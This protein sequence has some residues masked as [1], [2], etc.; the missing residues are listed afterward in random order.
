MIMKNLTKKNPY[1]GNM[2]LT[3]S[4]ANFICERIKERLKPIVYEV[5]NI[6]THTVTVDGEAYDSNKR[7]ENIEEKLKE[8][9][10]L[11]SVSAYLRTAI[12]EKDKRID[13][14]VA[15]SRTAYNEA[16][17]EIKKE[18]ISEEFVENPDFETFLATL[19][20]ESQVEYNNAYERNAVLNKSIK[21]INKILDAIV[22]T[23]LIQ[24]ENSKQQEIKT[25]RFPLYSQEELK[26][27]IS[28][29][30]EEITEHN[31]VLDKYKQLYKEYEVKCKEEYQEEAERIEYEYED[32]VEKLKLEKKTEYIQAKEQVANYRIIVP[33]KYKEVIAEL[34]SVKQ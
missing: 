23:P 21:D 20:L 11:Y 17:D 33:N 4:E 8:I 32:K 5:N 34:S 26:K 24:I 1:Y 13:D 28:D 29:L 2:G 31:I 15:K 25:E 10:E 7:V 22:K 14:I 30:N 3:S 16:K 27:L 18:E 19:E 12:K 9:A 6:N